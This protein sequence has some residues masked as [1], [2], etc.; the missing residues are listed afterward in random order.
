MNFLSVKP[1][2]AVAGKKLHSEAVE[3]AVQKKKENGACVNG[4]LCV[5]FKM[6]EGKLFPQTD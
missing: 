3:P 2:G 4:P 1:T 5:C 6:F